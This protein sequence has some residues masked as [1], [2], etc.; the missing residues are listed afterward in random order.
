MENNNNTQ[1][2]F[3]FVSHDAAMEYESKREELA[4][5]VDK[6]MFDKSDIEKLIGARGGE[7]MVNNHRN[8]A[9]LIAMVLSFKR[10][11]VLHNI[12]PWV[13]RAYHNHGFSYDYFLRALE[14]WIEAMYKILAQQHAAEIEPL[15]RRLIELHA[16][17][18][19]RSKKA[20]HPDRLSMVA[21]RWRSAF[22]NYS[23]ALLTGDITSCIE[24]AESN[25]KSRH[26]AIDFHLNVIQPAL[27]W[28][29][30]LWERGEI[31][32]SVEHMATAISS[33]VMSGLTWMFRER[34]IRFGRATVLAV[35]GEQHELGA[36]MVA[37]T[38]ETEG[39]DV[40]F[41]GANVPVRDLFVHLA[42]IRP[43][44]LALSVALPYNVAHAK[45]IIDRLKKD[46]SF[47]SVNIIVGGLAFLSFPNLWKEI[48]AD[49]FAANAKEAAESAKKFWE[50][51]RAK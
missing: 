35:T 5:Y 3:S 45:R 26:D 37:D 49:A 12:L 24:I 42:A 33:R 40:A 39:W 34:T 44:I 47:K 20:S 8:H 7:L 10:F 30:D 36:W 21:E 19:A 6:A 2:G 11:D 1:F 17:S 50:A 48:G 23:N 15:Y 27:Y 9:A 22:L 51:I 13:Y 32:V 43:H 16:D 4:R 28:I 38:L 18:I 46:D 29:G 14:C 25:C 41:L 31:T